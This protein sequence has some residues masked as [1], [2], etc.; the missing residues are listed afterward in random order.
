MIAG[1]LFNFFQYKILAFPERNEFLEPVPFEGQ[2]VFY[3]KIVIPEDSFNQEFVFLTIINQPV[4]FSGPE[5]VE[6][7][8]GHFLLLKILF[9]FKH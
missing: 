2:Q 4:L 6:R 7:N 8:P 1:L 3:L 5:H 9:P